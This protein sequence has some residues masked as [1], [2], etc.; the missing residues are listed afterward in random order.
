MHRAARA[1][2]IHIRCR[3]RHIK[4]AIRDTSET[5][6][7]ARC[8]HVTDALGWVAAASEVCITAG[9][10]DIS[11]ELRVLTLPRCALP[12]TGPPLLGR[13]LPAAPSQRP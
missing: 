4:Y 12:C 3:K 9:R 6:S 2:N 7:I 8:V 11:W 10:A 5:I 13:R 1:V